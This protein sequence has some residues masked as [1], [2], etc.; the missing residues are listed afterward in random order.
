[1]RKNTAFFICAFFYAPY[2]PFLRVF[3]LTPYRVSLY[4]L[5]FVGQSA[6]FLLAPTWFFSWKT[7]ATGA[8]VAGCFLS[9]A[10]TL[11]SLY[12]FRFFRAQRSSTGQNQR[13]GPVGLL[14]LHF[15]HKKTAW[16]AGGTSGL[17]KQII[18]QVKRL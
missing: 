7:P 6:S 3:V 14:R 2:F 4:F 10:L 17:I 16:C 8:P 9:S 12:A 1:M 5:F 18:Q 13:Q 15:T 11:F